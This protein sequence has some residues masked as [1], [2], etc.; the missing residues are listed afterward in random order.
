[1]SDRSITIWNLLVGFTIVSLIATSF[2]LFPMNSKYNRL[3]AAAAD[4]NSERT[5]SL[6][7][8]LPIWKAGS[9]NVVTMHLILKTPPCFLQMFLLLQMAQVEE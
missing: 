6:R 4:L 2:K 3:K 1:M 5:K 9:R 8:L 7:I